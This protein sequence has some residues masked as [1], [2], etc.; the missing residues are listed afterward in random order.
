MGVKEGED[1]TIRGMSIL[2]FR[3]SEKGLQIVEQRDYY[4]F[5]YKED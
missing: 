1:I 3:K 5:L 2:K 4:S